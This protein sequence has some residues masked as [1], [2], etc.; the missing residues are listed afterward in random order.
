M[1][2]VL[3]ILLDVNELLQWLRYQISQGLNYV[4]GGGVDCCLERRKEDKFHNLHEM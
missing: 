4:F 3:E 2:Q 1:V